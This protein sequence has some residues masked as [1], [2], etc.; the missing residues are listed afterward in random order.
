MTSVTQGEENGVVYIDGRKIDGHIDDEICPKCSE[1]RIYADD[2]DAYFCGA[3]N[4]WLDSTCSDVTCEYCRS[5]PS[6][7]L[8]S[9]KNDSF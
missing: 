7:P 9:L 3:C 2:Y 1:P 5:R 6:K 4:E 8:D